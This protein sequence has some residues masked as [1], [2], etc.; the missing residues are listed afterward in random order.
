MVSVIIPIHN[1]EQII[2]RSIQSVLSQ[3]YTDFEIVVIDDCSTDN[4]VSVV[5]SLNDPRIHLHLNKENK[6]AAGSRN[7]G[8]EK[9]KGTYIAFL[10]S[11]D[12]WLPSKLNYQ[13]NLL[14]AAKSKY[15]FSA[16]HT[17]AT[18]N[19]D[20]RPAQETLIEKD[21]PKNLTLTQKDCLR[22]VPL[23]A[24]ICSLIAPKFL[25]EELGNF[26]EEIPNS[27]DWE[28][29]IRLSKAADCLYIDEP[30]AIYF[31]AHNHGQQTSNA[32]RN[33]AGRKV[34]F[35]K[36]EE[37]LLA[38]PIAAWKALRA[39]T[40]RACESGNIKDAFRWLK[41]GAKYGTKKDVIQ[42]IAYY[43]KWYIRNTLHLRSK[44][45]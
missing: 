28:I 33:Y 4:S 42:L 23:K 3:T 20:Y 16:G 27:E 36:Y 15:V 40:H 31:R 10:D 11:D 22:G 7:L 29:F 21:H 25:F 41:L 35:R 14:S 26:S 17:I 34:I 43:L 44:T 2:A 19:F 38:D 13:V 24:H 45:L 6:G 32:Q 37:Q 9:A 18:K 1:R 8:I 30:I 12:L 5:N 39:L